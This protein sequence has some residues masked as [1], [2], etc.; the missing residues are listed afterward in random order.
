MKKCE[1]CDKEKV[2]YTDDICRCDPEIL[3]TA[4]GMAI[5]ELNDLGE[6]HE[7]TAEGVVDLFMRAAKEKHDKGR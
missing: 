4:L 7:L 6:H 2:V 5:M 1:T 3:G